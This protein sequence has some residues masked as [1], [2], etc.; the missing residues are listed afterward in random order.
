MRDAAQRVLLSCS[1][2]MLLLPWFT[3]LR[4]LCYTYSARGEG[5]RQKEGAEPG[6]MM[7]LESRYS[8][9]YSYMYYWYTRVLLG[10]V[11]PYSV[12]RGTL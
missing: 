4:H 3:A 6:V 7:S 9:V 2:M 11:V 10:V 8:T 5:E 1:S 12:L